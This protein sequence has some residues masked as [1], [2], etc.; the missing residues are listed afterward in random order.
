MPIGSKPIEMVGQRFG[1]FVVIARDGYHGHMAAWRCRCDCGNER[2][3][4]GAPL[5]QGRSNSC[6]CLMRERVS[7]TNS[8]HGMT[9]SRTWRTWRS[10]RLR[11]LNPE[12]TGYHNYGG[13]GITICDRWSAFER[14]LEDMG[15]RPDGTSL[16]RYPDSDGPYCKENCRWAT[17]LQQGEKRRGLRLVTS[18]GKTQSIAAW[19]RELGLPRRQVEQMFGVR[20]QR[21]DPGP[22]G[23]GPG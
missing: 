21:R 12:A 10:M 11:C 7:E 16:D 14:F 18:N 22:R 3:V 2:T 20:P 6:G 19:T 8:T 9:S 23:P 5:R 17:P 4:G 1:R 15:E 13:R